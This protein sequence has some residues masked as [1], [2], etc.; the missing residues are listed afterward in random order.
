MK[1]KKAKEATQA[2][3]VP[4]ASRDITEPENA[5]N[6]ALKVNPPPSTPGRDTQYP[7][8]APYGFPPYHPYYPPC[9]PMPMP[10]SPFY[11]QAPY[12]LSPHPQMYPPSPWALYPPGAA[13][14]MPKQESP[15]RARKDP[16][17]GSSPPL[18]KCGVQEFCETYDLGQEIA[19][20]L[21]KLGFCIG[22]DLEA[23]TMDEWE[24]AG[25]KVLAR[26]RTLKAYKKFKSDVRK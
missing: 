8:P 19:D 18:P 20:G 12:T 22:D 5:V 6:K 24:H 17:Q 15:L 14:V 11:P 10:H 2:H 16:M 13:A 3:D 4:S 9:Q 23:V 21:E 1:V 26:V 7:P 25:I